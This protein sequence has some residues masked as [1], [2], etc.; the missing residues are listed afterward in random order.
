MSEIILH[1]F[2]IVAVLEARN[3]VRVAQIVEAGGIKSN[4]RSYR[5]EVFIQR[6]VWDMAAESVCKYKVVGVIPCA[7]RSDGGERLLVF[8]FTQLF[9]YRRRRCYGAR[10]IRFGGC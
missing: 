9:Y 1:C 8:D 5:L 7:P 10:S 3:G 4:A 2:Y 6:V